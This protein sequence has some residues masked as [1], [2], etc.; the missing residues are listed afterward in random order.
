MS[1]HLLWAVSAQQRQYCPPP[2]IFGK[3]TPPFCFILYSR[4]FSY[5]SCSWYLWRRLYLTRKPST[6][7]PSLFFIKCFASFFLSLYPTQTFIWQR[8]EKHILWKKFWREGFNPLHQ[9]F[10]LLGP[11]YFFPGSCAL[12]ISSVLLAL[13]PVFLSPLL[14]HQIHLDTWKGVFPALTISPTCNCVSNV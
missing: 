11:H 4:H 13:P 1:F 2:M 12:Q 3:C 6:E 5:L 10:P 14:S 7:P 8:K 9:S